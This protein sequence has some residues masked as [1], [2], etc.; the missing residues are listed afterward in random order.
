MDSSQN[1][2]N[3]S[4]GLWEIW[5]K[6]H[7]L[8][9]VTVL[10]KNISK[11][12]Y[13]VSTHNKNKYPTW[14]VISVIHIKQFELQLTLFFSYRTIKTSM[15]LCVMPLS[16]TFVKRWPLFPSL[17]RAWMLFW[18]SLCSHPFIRT[19]RC[20][21]QVKGE[22]NSMNIFPYSLYFVHDRLDLY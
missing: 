10:N 17:L 6:Y 12:V 14:K 22:P 18:Q 8:W 3:S 5:S 15:S 4:V 13:T 19:G 7:T 21:L 2:L 16:M 1:C 11:G 9:T 20:R